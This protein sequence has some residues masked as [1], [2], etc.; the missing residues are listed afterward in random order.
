MLEEM[1]TK[2]QQL[3][4]GAEPKNEPDIG[5]RVLKL[6]DSNMKE[7][8][9][10][11]Q[12][13]VEPQ[14]NFDGLVDNIKSDRTAEDLL[15]QV[16]LDLGVLLSSKIEVKQMEG[17]PVHFVNDGY[18]VAC[19]EAVTDAV[20]TEIAK[21]KPYYAVFR[22]NSFASDSTLVNF[23]QIF[24]TYSPSTQRKVL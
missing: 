2:N 23:E 22:D 1:R 15:F 6:D 17:K 19:F 7:V 11:P 8:Y 20:V 12:D 5:F 3:E 10:T 24:K 21:G 18:L 4:I 16:M 14:F 13:Y 9:Y